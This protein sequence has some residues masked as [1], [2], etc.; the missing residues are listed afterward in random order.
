[1][2]KNQVIKRIR[3]WKEELSGEPS[4]GNCNVFILASQGMK[5]NE[6]TTHVV[7]RYRGPTNRYYLP[8]R[9]PSEEDK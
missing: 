4:L 2:L 5:A 3:L 7:K 9:F 8:L 1:M 6:A